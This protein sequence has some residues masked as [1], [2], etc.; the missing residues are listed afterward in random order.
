MAVELNLG[1]EFQRVVESS[2]DF[3]EVEILALDARGF[4]YVRDGR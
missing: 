2:A 4:G 3:A 1:M